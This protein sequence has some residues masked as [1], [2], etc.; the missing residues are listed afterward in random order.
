[1]GTTSGI[2]KG[3]SCFLTHC[4]TDLI[5]EAGSVWRLSINLEHETLG[6]R[7]QSVAYRSTFRCDGQNGGQN[8]RVG[9][10]RLASGLRQPL[11]SA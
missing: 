7:I 5:D 8:P 10:V 11:D 6:V 4:V 9:A 1:M 2:W 3:C